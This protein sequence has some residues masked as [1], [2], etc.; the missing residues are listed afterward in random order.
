M[1]FVKSHPKYRP[2][3]PLFTVLL[4]TGCRIGEALALRWDNCDFEKNIIDITHTLTLRCNR[5]L[6]K[7]ELCISAPK[8]QYSSREIPMF[9]AVRKALLEERDKQQVKNIVQPVLNGYSGFVFVDE[10]NKVVLPR[11]VYCVLGC[12]IRDQ[13]IEEYELA[14]K[15]HRD[16][17]LLPHF[18]AHNL[19]H[20]F[21]TRMCESNT[22]I[23]VVQEIMGH[24]NISIT[25]EIYNEATRDSKIQAFK[26]MNDI[27]QIC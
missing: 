19:R 15:Q 18:S 8:T 3:L 4:G 5:N 22:N 26:N 7:T 21:C 17:L 9:D 25:M 13:N 27:M 1:G 11:T 14:K 12:I 23:K 20:T 6:G 16:P 24:S 10:E 2:W